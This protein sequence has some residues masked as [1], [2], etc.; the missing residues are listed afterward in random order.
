MSIYYDYIQ[1]LMHVKAGLNFGAGPGI[2]K[3]SSEIFAKEGTKVVVSD[4]NEES[5]NLRSRL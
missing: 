1:K 5:G 2:G 3:V 4:I